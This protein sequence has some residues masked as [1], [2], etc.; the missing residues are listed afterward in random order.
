MP[1]DHALVRDFRV[2]DISILEDEAKIEECLRELAGVL[3]WMN[4][5]TH[6]FKG[7]DR[8]TFRLG[9]QINGFVINKH[10]IIK[11]LTIK[12]GIFYRAQGNYCKITIYGVNVSGK[13][14]CEINQCLKKHFGTLYHPQ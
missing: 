4:C 1:M 3:L 14:L 7:E 10:P 13:L 5:E 2:N 9:M 11:Y 12:Q 8:S 6:I